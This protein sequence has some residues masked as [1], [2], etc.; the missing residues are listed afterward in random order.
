MG[1]IFQDEPPSQTTHTTGRTEKTRG[2]QAGHGPNTPVRACRILLKVVAGSRHEEVVGVLGE[3][4]K[5]KVSAPAE[6]GRANEAVCGLLAR[7]LGVPPRA[8]SVVSGVSNPEKVVRVEG[9]SASE[10]EDRLIKSA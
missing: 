3:R 5:L 2:A 4:L 8:V 10:A 7:V 1:A 9:V 6:Q